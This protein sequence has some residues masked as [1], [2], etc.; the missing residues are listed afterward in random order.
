M[1]FQVPETIPVAPV[2]T[3]PN[4]EYSG[5]PAGWNEVNPVPLPDIQTPSAPLTDAEIENA[6]NWLTDF[7][8]WASVQSGL[9]FW[10]AAA[11][12]VAEIN[13]TLTGILLGMSLLA[14][15]GYVIWRWGI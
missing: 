7:S 11:A 1:I 3:L 12:H 10:F 2:E 15:L 13:E 9:A 5:L 8:F 4:D 6:H 14:V